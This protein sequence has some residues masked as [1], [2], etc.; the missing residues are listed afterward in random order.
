MRVRV[1]DKSE[2]CGVMSK[3]GDESEGNQSE[4]G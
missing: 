3:A 2:G 1:G 4:V